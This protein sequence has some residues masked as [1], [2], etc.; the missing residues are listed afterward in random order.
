MVKG[1]SIY[2]KQKPEQLSLSAITKQQS[3]SF[4]VIGKG[5]SIITSVNTKVH[6]NKIELF[7]LTEIE[8]EIAVSISQTLKVCRTSP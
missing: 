8:I 5:T 4:S 7:G 3:V 1:T 6:F 2:N